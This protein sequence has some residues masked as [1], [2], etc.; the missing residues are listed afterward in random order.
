[1]GERPPILFV[2][3]AWSVRGQNECISGEGIFVQL[4]SVCD[5]MKEMENF[6]T[7]H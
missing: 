5:V 3:F 2:D 4:Y 7:E 1:M 6:S